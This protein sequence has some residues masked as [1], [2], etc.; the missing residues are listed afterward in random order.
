MS[1]DGLEDMAF[2]A[3][4]VLAPSAPATPEEEQ[5]YWDWVFGKAEED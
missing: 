4:E 3:H 5:S 2:P 1:G